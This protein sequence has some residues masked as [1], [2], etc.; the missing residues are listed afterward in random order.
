MTAIAAM[1]A[2]LVSFELMTPAVLL[3]FV[4]M[5]EAAG[6]LT[7]PAWQSIVPQ[8]VPRADLPQAIAAN[9][10][11][12]N[13]SRAVGPALGGL[14]IVSISIGA[15]FW[16]NVISNF[17]II[18]ALLWWRSPPQ[19]A[20]RLPAERFMSAMRTGIRYARYNYELRA[21]L[22]RAA[23]FFCS[24]ARIGRSCHSWRE[25]K[26][27]AGRRSMECCSGPSALAPLGAPSFY[28]G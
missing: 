17:G 3:I 22:M 11:G 27:R 4:F 2:A 28:P 23:A 25:I 19:N 7:T 13:I 1:F 18:G 6:A 21:T 12:V 24:R 14:I 20:S 9:S 10:V 16:L 26:S 15:P 8:L 5:I